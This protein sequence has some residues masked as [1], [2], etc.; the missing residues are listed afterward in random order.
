MSACFER[1]QS[2]GIDLSAYNSLENAADVPLVVQALDYDE[3]NFYGVSY[4]TLLGLHLMRNH[5]EDFAPSSS[6]V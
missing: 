3:Y 2:E 5:P 4:G 6:I 1:L